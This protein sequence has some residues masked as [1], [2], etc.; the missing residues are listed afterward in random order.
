MKAK[1][2]S[3]NVSVTSGIS[4]DLRRSLDTI[5]VFIRGVSEKYLIPFDNVVELL[6][7]KEKN[8]IPSSILRDQKLGIMEAVI[9]YLKED[10]NLTYH[11]IAELLNRDD[12]VV[13]TTYNNAIKK[14]KDRFS[15]SGP[16]VWIPVKIFSEKSLAP[17]ESVSK[18]L[19]ENVKMDFSSSAKLLNRNP[20]SIWACYKRAAAK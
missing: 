20:K 6:K 13:W 1:S 12:R 3:E 17:L 7:K 11:G 19:V 9:K 5:D 2:E 14:R 4:E 8:S 16:N 10:I 15:V 18:F